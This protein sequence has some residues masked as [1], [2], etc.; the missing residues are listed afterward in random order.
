MSC[1]RGPH[2]SSLLEAQWGPPSLAARG[3][4]AGLEAW[5]LEERLV[6]ERAE[7][8][9]QIRLLLSGQLER[10]DRR[11]GVGMAFA[12]LRVVLD[13]GLQGLERAVVHVRRCD[14]DVAQAR[15]LELAA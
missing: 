10:V 7:E 8:R 2:A 9:D 4:A 5:I 15:D 11:V 14:G 6:G 13:H 1:S 3:S 12:S